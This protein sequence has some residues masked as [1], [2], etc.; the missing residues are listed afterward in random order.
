MGK[1]QNASITTIA[2][3]PL[4]TRPVAPVH[5]AIFRLP[6]PPHSPGGS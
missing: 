1:H 2:T 4:A 5:T 6:G 3:E